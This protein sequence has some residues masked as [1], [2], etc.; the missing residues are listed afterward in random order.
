MKKIYK[1]L[2]FS[3]IVLFLSHFV[4]AQDRHLA[5]SVVKN[6][7]ES[8]FEVRHEYFAPVYASPL[9]KQWKEDSEDQMKYI[10]AKLKPHVACE[11]YIKAT[12]IASVS[13]VVYEKNLT[14]ALR[15][16]EQILAEPFAN[17]RCE[18]MRVSEVYHL[19]FQAK[20]HEKTIKILAESIKEAKKYG[21]NDLQIE[22]SVRHALLVA[23]A[24]S[25]EKGIA[26]LLETAELAAKLHIS[27]KKQT[28][29]WNE[30]GNLN[31]GVKDYKRAE[32]YWRKSL[33]IYAQISKKNSEFVGCANN[34][35]LAMR[36][37]N[38]ISEA[39]VAYDSALQYAIQVKDTAWTGIIAG[40]M[41][42]IYAEQGNYQ[43][44][45][46]LLE[47]NIYYSLQTHQWDEVPISYPK[48]AKCFIHL[49]QFD[50]AKDALDSL[51]K[52]LAYVKNNAYD[53]GEIYTLQIRTAK[54]SAWAEWYVAQGKYAEAYRFQN[55][56]IEDYKNYEKL[57][58]QENFNRIQTE[59][60]VER[61]E[62]ENLLLKQQ[63]EA[64][65]E[66]IRRQRIL[67]MVVV[68][69]LVFFVG[70]AIVFYRMMK[71]RQRLN[72]QLSAQ[73]EEINSQKEALH[74]QNGQLE[75]LN[76][77][78]NRLFAIISHDLRSP[79]NNLKGVLDIMDMDLPKEQQKQI[80]QDTTRLMDNTFQTLENL[81]NW[82]K[83]QMGGSHYFPQ[84]ID[85]EHITYQICSLLD[86]TAASKNIELDNQIEKETF[87]WADRDH[88]ELIL[89]NLIG[90][91]LKFTPEGGK[92]WVKSQKLK[93]ISDEFVQISV[94]DSG[95][96]ISEERLL[97]LFDS[98]KI[99][100]TRG[101]A[102]EKG[103]GLGVVMCK[104]FV[105]QNGGTLQVR[106][107]IGE[108]TIFVF[109]LP[110]N[111]LENRQSEQ[112]IF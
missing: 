104:E 96:G 51:D 1:L 70:V 58:N 2:S 86:Q 17:S 83:W 50:R 103:T 106:S 68:S 46:N 98:Q 42:D 64:D 30:L 7:I 72:D 59:L 77:T 56:Y 69:F 11:E 87:A 73:K 38:R 60:D 6:F 71:Q 24:E 107:K 40:N 49:N 44:A 82:A 3:F 23:G 88:V 57:T 101:T 84:K 41:G 32:K 108:G 67:N 20:D 27:V 19:F 52:F 80:L 110:Q 78:K 85:I 36:K 10:L 4:S 92:I 47:K 54:N 12:A 45:I 65:H 79:I 105:E 81:L 109:T 91:A 53:Y 90:N 62:K 35:A 94:C 43:K 63:T 48:L 21:Y 95:V 15:F 22:Y 111:W 16:Y 39:L 8:K 18:V 102:G 5:D 25:N 33:L 99:N 26:L 9:F 74:E 76:G 13:F 66:E 112:S 14:K 97:K 29:A 61:K 28:E 89:R 100:S 31:Y 34:I 55:E 93:N 37:Q 75:Q